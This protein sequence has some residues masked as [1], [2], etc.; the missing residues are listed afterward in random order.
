MLLVMPILAE[1]VRIL[2]SVKWDLLLD[3]FTD[4][5]SK[6]LATV[7]F[8]KEDRCVWRDVGQISTF[9]PSPTHLSLSL[10]LLYI[11]IYIVPAV[12]TPS[13][14]ISGQHRQLLPVVVR[15]QNDTG[16]R[17]FSSSL[18]TP[19]RGPQFTNGHFKFHHEGK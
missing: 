8:V 11:Y 13:T 1:S 7:S 12:R 10:S 18:Y 4:M 5:L 15:Y 16:S 2:Y 9:C 14:C 17:S 19:P 3:V 6:S